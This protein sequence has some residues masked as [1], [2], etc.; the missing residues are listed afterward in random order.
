MSGF[1]KWSAD[2]DAKLR[3]LH[4]S[5]LSL[6]GIARTLGLTSGQVHGR[7]WKLGLKRRPAKREAAPVEG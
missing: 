6:S 1:K 4:E 2:D 5:G 3:E 7:V